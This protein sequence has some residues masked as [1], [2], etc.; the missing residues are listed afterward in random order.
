MIIASDILL[1][2]KEF[3]KLIQ[4]ISTILNESGIM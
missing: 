3:P 4:T 2:I 1:Y